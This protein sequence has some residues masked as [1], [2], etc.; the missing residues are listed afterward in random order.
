MTTGEF[1]SLVEYMREV[2]TKFNAT[3]DRKLLPLIRE[4]EGRVDGILADRNSRIR[5]MNGDIIQGDVV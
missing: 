2:Q 4:L 3:Q 5:K 1:A